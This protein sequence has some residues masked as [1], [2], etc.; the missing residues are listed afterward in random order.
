M[1]G[2]SSIREPSR[3]SCFEQRFEEVRASTG[4]IRSF[5]RYRLSACCMPA[6]S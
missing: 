5:K 2:S 6:L 4:V 1:E 3:M